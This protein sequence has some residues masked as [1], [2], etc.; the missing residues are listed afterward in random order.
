MRALILSWRDL[1]HPRG[2]GSEVF[3]QNVAKYGAAA[4]HEV[5]FFCA[6]A[7]GLAANEEVDGYRI[8]RRG[9]RLSVYREARRYFRESGEG[10]FD[11]VL[12]VVNT[13]PFMAPQWAGSTPVVALIHQTAEE[14]WSYETAWPL[15]WVG[16]YV[17]EPNWLKVYRSTP[18]LTVSQSSRVSLERFGLADITVIPEGVD[19]PIPRPLPRKETTPTA[20]F[21]GRLSAN[22]RPID[23]IQ[24]ISIVRQSLPEARLWVVGDGPLRSK[25]EKVSGSGIDFF[26]K[27]DSEVKQDLMASAHALVATG[28]RE[29]WG[30]TVS[31]AAHLGTR[32]V[33]YDVP[34]LRDSVP[35]AKGVLCVPNPEALARALCANLPVWMKE[36]RAD[37]GSAGVVTWEA[38]A[39]MVWRE[40]AKHLR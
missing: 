34:G 20:V 9:S 6:A 23:A 29:G 33:G 8:V 21:V 14:V 19:P 7:P 39:I 40:L 5:T 32:T 24:A 16:R 3:T 30:L 27:V 35:A 11:I 25:L 13:R 2:G 4:G 38:V 37:L 18:V 10:V 12:D 28:V 15:S 22:K 31:E 1:K 17:L 26:G 36:G